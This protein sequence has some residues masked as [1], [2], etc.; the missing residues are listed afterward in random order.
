MFWSDDNKESDLVGF[1]KHY[2]A[3][4][5]IKVLLRINVIVKLRSIITAIQHQFTVW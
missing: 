1:A 4:I 2:N 3:G 5:I